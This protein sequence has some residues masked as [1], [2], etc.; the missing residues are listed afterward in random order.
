QALVLALSRTLE[1]R[2]LARENRRLTE[3]IGER[4]RLVELV[5]RSAAMQALYV[6]VGKLA[7]TDATV[8]LAGESGTGKELAARALHQ[9]SARRARSFVAVNC[10]AIPENLLE[11]EFFGVER[12]AFTGA[13]R[14]R[15][16]R[17]ELAQG[18]TLFLDEIGELPLSLQPK[19]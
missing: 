8:L 12:G 1:R 14:T 15:P 18:G 9:L 4:D 3:E 16:G 17:F 7:A 6:R 19:L 11:S 13:D 5:G 2:R 10:A